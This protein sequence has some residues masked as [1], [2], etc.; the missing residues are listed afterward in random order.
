MVDHE[1]SLQRALV[2][3]QG[4]SVG[5]A[6]GERFFGPPG[7]AQAMIAERQLPPPRWGYTDDTAMAMSIVDI[8]RNYRTIDQ[9]RLANS[10]AARH[11]AEPMRGYGAGAHR[12]L[13]AIHEGASWQRASADLF[14]G[15]GSFGN[16]G[17]MRA[18]PLGAYFAH[19][20]NQLVQE[21][22]RSAEVTH[23]H[24]EGQAGAIAVALAAAYASLRRE[25]SLTPEVGDL[26]QFVQD[27]SPAS[28]TRDGLQRA[29]ELKEGT[30]VDEA[31]QVLGAG[32]RVSS[33]DTVPFALWCASHHLEKFEEALWTTVAGL[34]DRD[35]T[36]AIV[37]SI[38]VLSAGLD[39]IP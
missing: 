15:Q 13:T 10:F 4:L 1:A 26:L 34:G 16:G 23:A 2:S 37:G 17:A 6:F 8:L 35:T 12:L 36:C 21:A 38:V 28:D 33:Q 7:R 14:G 11:H 32:E 27:R 31:A 19:D 18:G 25:E 9:T 24:P 20:L 39:S 29:R 5:D 30:G 3:L 22:R